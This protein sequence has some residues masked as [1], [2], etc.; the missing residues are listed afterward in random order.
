LINYAP[1]EFNV[2]EKKYLFVF[3]YGAMLKFLSFRYSH[4][5]FPVGTKNWH[6]CRVLSMEHSSNHKLYKQWYID[7]FFL[8]PELNIKTV[9]TCNLND[10]SFDLLTDWLY[11]Y[12][13]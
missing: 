11:C 8:T 13:F 4:L 1:F 6:L 10:I 5:G 7:T 3:P 9:P 2:S 12:L